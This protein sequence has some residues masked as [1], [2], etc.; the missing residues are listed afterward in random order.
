[1]YEEEHKFLSFHWGWV[2]DDT[3]SSDFIQ[4]VLTEKNIWC[5]RS[6]ITAIGKT[7]TQ[8]D[9]FS[10]KGNQNWSFASSL[11]LH[12]LFFQLWKQFMQKCL[13]W[14]HEHIRHYISFLLSHLTSGGW[15]YFSHAV[16]HKNKMNIRKINE[17]D[18]GTWNNGVMRMFSWYL[19]LC[20]VEAVLSMGADSE[21]FWGGS[22]Y[23]VGGNSENYPV[24][25]DSTFSM[26]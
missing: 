15:S 14:A 19:F 3:V 4:L 10:E 18:E 13:R 6:K 9:L 12:V 5:L 16:W 8:S 17:A 2:G 1:M 24:F 20:Y 11:Q 21:R 23:C 25:Q 22:R 7:A 26:T